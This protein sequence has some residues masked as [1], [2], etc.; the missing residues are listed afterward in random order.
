MAQSFNVPSNPKPPVA[1][2]IISRMLVSPH[3]RLIRAIV[4]DVPLPS[5][6][7]S[8]PDTHNVTDA[9]PL[10]GELMNCVREMRGVLSEQ[11]VTRDKFERYHA[12]Y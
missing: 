4:R 11:M 1:V 5:F 2:A 6:A 12:E 3:K 7:T 10:L 9:P 8:I